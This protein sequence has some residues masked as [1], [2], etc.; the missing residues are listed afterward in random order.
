MVIEKRGL[1]FRN[2]NV[3]IITLFHPRLMVSS[4]PLQVKLQTSGQYFQ[5]S[6]SQ[7]LSF[8]TWIIW[9]QMR[10]NFQSIKAQWAVTW[11]PKKLN[12]RSI[13]SERVFTNIKGLPLTSMVDS[14]DNTQYR[15]EWGPL[16]C[17]I[18]NWI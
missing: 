10:R 15:T 7:N 1:I 8:H 5:L 13:E 12:L 9:A 11:H 2:V 17:K 14:V 3:S 16:K 18:H 4:Y 6:R